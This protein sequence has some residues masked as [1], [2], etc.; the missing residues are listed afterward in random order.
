MSTFNDQ[1]S[2][3]PQLTH[4]TGANVS[5]GP[6]PPSNSSA[7][8][9]CYSSVSPAA[10]SSTSGLGSSL[11]DPKSVDASPGEVA[12][13]LGNAPFSCSSGNG[14]G[15]VA[16]LQSDSNMIKTEVCLNF[17]IYNYITYSFDEYLIL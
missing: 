6:T 10:L 4:P 16:H 15:L 2:A 7:S 8:S 13:M 14:S 11:S 3:A 1:P 5:T 17:E 12:T 9:S